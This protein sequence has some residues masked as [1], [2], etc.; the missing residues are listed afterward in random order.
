[1]SNAI[2]RLLS[3]AFCAVFALSL[4]LFS[5]A[6]S[7]NEYGLGLTVASDESNASATLNVKLKNS[8]SFDVNGV[9]I[10]LT[11]PEGLDSEQAKAG[12]DGYSV[13][14]DTLS[15]GEV[16]ENGFVFVSREAAP[17]S[18]DIFEKD[19]II[20]T[21]L[22]V[23]GAVVIVA[24]IAFLAIRKKRAA[25]LMLAVLMLLPCAGIFGVHAIGKEDMK[26]FQLEETVSING[27]SY[28]VVLTVSYLANS[29]KKSYFNFETDEEYEIYNKGTVT[30]LTTD[31]GGVAAANGTVKA[32]TYEIKSEGNGETVTGTAQLDGCD[33]SVEKLALVPGE[34]EV[35]ITAELADGDKQTKTYS[36]NYDRGTLYQAK[37]SEIKEENGHRY[38]DNV[39]NIYFTGAVSEERKEEILSENSLVRIGE[40]NGVFLVQARANAKSLEELEALCFKI[41]EL[42][43][44][45]LA[46]T[47]DVVDLELD[48][49][50]NDP[51]YHNTN[52]TEKWNESIPGGYNWSVEA[53]EAVSAWEYE[54]YFG[55]AKAGV[56]DGGFK[57]DHEDYASGLITFPETIYKTGNVENNHGT[58][59]AGII[60]ATRNNGLGGSG[61]LKDVKIYAA[62]YTVGS[63]S[64]TVT[65]VINAT[66]S[67][68]E[69]GA[70]AVNISLGLSKGDGSDGT[71]PYV[72]MVYSEADLASTAGPCATALYALIN[73]EENA[74]E[75][76]VVQ[77]A[78]NGTIDTRISESTFRSDDATQNGLFCAVT[79]DVSSYNRYR[80]YGNLSKNAIQQVYNRIIVVGAIR[81]SS[82]NS[83]GAMFHM[84]ERSNGGDRVDI[85][86][87]GHQ[88]FSSIAGAVQDGVTYKY[89]FMSGT[90]QA[91]P[92]VTA[93]AAMCFAINPSFTGEQVKNIIRD[94]ANS[95]HTA[96]D[97]SLN[98]TAADGT[99][100]DYHP[101]E[102]DG[103]VIS[104]KLCAEAAL[105]TVCGPANYRYFNTIMTAAQNL[106]P[107]EYK[108]YEV[109]QAVLD[110]IDDDFY[111][112]YEFEQD[113]VTDKANELAA[114][115][116]KLEERDKADY[117]EVEKA[118]SEAAALDPTHYVDFSGVTAAVNAVVYGKY[119]DEQAEVDLMAK[120]IRDAI[121]ALEPLAKI[122]SSDFN[123]TADNTEAVVVIPPDYVGNLAEYLDAGKMTVT[124]SPNSKG[125][126]STGSTITLTD[127]SGN[128]EDKIYTVVTLGD[129]DGNAKADGEDAFIIGLY[130]NGM[131]SAEAAAQVICCDVDFNG[132]IDEEDFRML[133]RCGLFEDYI[134]NLYQGADQ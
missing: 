42:D 131:L 104:M 98:Y 5:S 115:M 118:K 62:S 35:T 13:L 105:R 113:K 37:E 33:W 70:T 57:T 112:L 39:I 26:S 87:P 34:N 82:S 58:H 84:W 4:C 53:V 100:L 125:N 54:G 27:K 23:I 134:S 109:V 30:R 36:L 11:V 8:N 10:D 119:A 123:V 96:L 122:S 16:Y 46:I 29:A 24:V 2:K 93:V 49:V 127:E 89:A 94:E 85:Y 128:T 25:A 3:A 132:V 81:N 103:R 110:T 75:F 69:Y 61:L 76:V 133:E 114:A 31:F 21:L 80:Y 28:P 20:P 56:V 88:V 65:N 92:I 41:Q 22:A 17:A 9:C 63:S 19:N 124:H 74:R 15:A 71:N 130:M 12:S 47:E 95:T 129:V 78:G 32:V 44:V 99:V 72:N 73:D 120:N 97:Y 45:R 108:N 117:T 126:Y 111:A 14:V 102:G 106:N 38:I 52:Y 40:M 101:F 59:V 1:M 60:G 50:P 90:S 43:E 64:N 51:W 66:V 83:K 79:P 48:S 91:A 18:A 86:A 77:S 116:D 68:I 121:A 55:T 67:E 107:D 6:L 7:T